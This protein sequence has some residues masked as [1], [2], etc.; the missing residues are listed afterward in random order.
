MSTFGRSNSLSLNTG[1]ANSLLYVP[2]F[3]LPNPQIDTS[4]FMRAAGHFGS[5]AA[6]LFNGVRIKIRIGRRRFDAIF[7]ES[8]RQHCRL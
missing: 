1:A 5:W 4:R 8:R 7:W 3:P 2:F 6:W